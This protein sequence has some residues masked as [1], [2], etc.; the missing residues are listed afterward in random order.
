M[1]GSHALGKQAEQLAAKFLVAK[2]YRILKTNWRWGKK[3]IDIICVYRGWLIIVE[4]KSRMMSIHP[5]AGELVG[6][7]KQ[8]NLITAAEG[9]IRIYNI[10]VP[11]RFDIISVV[12][13]GY[14]YD[15]E[16]IENAFFPEPG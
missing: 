10:T 8:R 15:I 3:E 2:G 5:M 14:E 1:N 13:S 4:V 16:H 12:F 6:I 11:T 7:K 9:F